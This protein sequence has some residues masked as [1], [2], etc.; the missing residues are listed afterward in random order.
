M[1]SY[2]HLT[3]SSV[4]T[5]RRTFGITTAAAVR[6]SS[7]SSSSSVDPPHFYCYQ[8]CKTCLC[9]DTCVYPCI[10]DTAVHRKLWY[11]KY[12][13][14]PVPASSSASYEHMYAVQVRPLLCCNI[15][16]KT[17][18]YTTTTAAAML[19]WHISYHARF[20]YPG[21]SA[22]AQQQ[23]QQQ[24]TNDPSFFLVLLLLLLYCIYL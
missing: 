20:T 24:M 5:Y 18:L 11:E 9:G 19:V 12:C 6:S 8:S 15:V 16:S 2:L 3:N 21:V 7:S 1:Y 10:C 14:A 23:L 4:G 13:R 17:M 22:A